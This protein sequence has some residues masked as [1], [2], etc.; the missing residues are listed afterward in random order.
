MTQREKIDQPADGNGGHFDSSYSVCE[1]SQ[2]L[3]DSIVGAC[4]SQLSKI[5]QP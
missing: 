2:M 1:G 3:D 5:E 4:G